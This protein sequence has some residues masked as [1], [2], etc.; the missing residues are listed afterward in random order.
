MSITRTI[1]AFLLSAFL[2]L[3]SAFAE[4]APVVVDEVHQ[5][6]EIPSVAHNVVE[7]A[8]EAT[9]HHGGGGLP[10]FDPSSW[11]SQIFWMTVVCIVLYTIFSKAILP[12][13]GGTLA[14][15][16]QHI[17]DHIADAERLSKEA[18]I[19]EAELTAALKDA[20]QKASEELRSAENDAKSKM[21]G[22]L[23]SYRERYERDISSA[24]GRIEDAKN[25]AM[26]DMNKIAAELASQMAE[27]LAG[28]S[29]D[30]SQAE[31]VVQSLSNKVRK[32]A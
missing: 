27:K 20:G 16:Q 31:T 21:D 17:D 2:P 22:A 28:I 29:A 5:E 10:Q 4:M 15:R 19:V 14:S 12:A 6:E 7:G 9:A 24:E 1:S 30:A 18:E 25:Q 23:N 26:Q 32:A 13:I 3:H 8:V 11:P